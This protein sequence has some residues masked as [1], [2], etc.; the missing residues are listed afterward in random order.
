MYFLIINMELHCQGI[1][2]FEFIRKLF[3]D[4]LYSV[5]SGWPWSLLQLP[6]IPPSSS[7]TSFPSRY[8]LFLSLIRN[9]KPSKEATTKHFKI[10]YI[11]IKQRP[12]HQY[13]TRKRAPR[14]ETRIR[15]PLRCMLRSPI[16]ALSW[17][18]Y[19]IHR[20][21]GE[22]C[23]GPV[24]AAS[25]ST[26]SKE[27]CL[28]DSE[29]LVF[30]LSLILSGSYTLSAS[31]FTVFPKLSRKESDRDIPFR[32]LGQNHILSKQLSMILKEA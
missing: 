15:D 20:G 1:V 29:G 23:T 8:T 26:S 5:F 13:W 7:L 10:K 21:P 6:H 4:E 31:S 32:D 25:V 2:K 3:I 19:C 28:A 18:L 16:T 11:K 27:L 24:L 30:L 12:S 17:E 9:E 14:A 22:E